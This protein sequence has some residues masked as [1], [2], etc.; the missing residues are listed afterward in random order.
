[1]PYMQLSL[2]FVRYVYS[3]D[4]CVPGIT[5]VAP[6]F[7]DNRICL[8]WELHFQRFNVAALS[9]SV[10]NPSRV[11]HCCKSRSLYSAAQASIDQ[12]DGLLT[13]EQGSQQLLQWDERIH[14]VCAALNNVIDSSAARQAT[15]AA[16]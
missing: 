2:Y 16:A 1:M 15:T 8:K 13:F 10:P 11:C 7:L 14:S 5:W 6:Q 9:L 3:H 4:V 12:V